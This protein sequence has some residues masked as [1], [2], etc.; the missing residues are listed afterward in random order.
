MENFDD[1]ISRNV[2]ALTAPS[3]EKYE[4]MLRT[5]E[6]S[7]DKLFILRYETTKARYV[8]L[9]LRYSFVRSSLTPE[10][11]RIV[12]ATLIS[13]RTRLE[14]D[15]SEYTLLTGY[16]GDKVRRSVKNALRDATRLFC[17]RSAS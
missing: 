16:D 6:E 14:R 12:E 2:A 11:Q 10:R 1:T 9:A 17:K 8:K 7:R 4:A 13:Y 15:R 5:L 3:R